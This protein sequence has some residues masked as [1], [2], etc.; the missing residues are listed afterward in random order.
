M[1]IFHQRYVKYS[2]CRLLLFGWHTY[3]EVLFRVFLE[4]GGEVSAPEKR[5]AEEIIRLGW[6]NLLPSLI[7]DGSDMNITLD[8]WEGFK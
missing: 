6:H 1:K 5:Y 8:V 4:T 2:R 3:G 7:I